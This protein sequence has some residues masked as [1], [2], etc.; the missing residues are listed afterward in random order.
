MDGHAGLRG[1]RVTC[2]DEYQLGGT[3][4]HNQLEL[5]S[6]IHSGQL[7]KQIEQHFDRLIAENMLVQV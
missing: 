5:G 7:P 4:F 6:Q 1:Q 2:P 3:R